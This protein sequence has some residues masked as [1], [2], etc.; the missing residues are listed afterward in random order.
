M[1]KAKVFIY[2]CLLI[3][4]AYRNLESRP[5]TP[6]DENTALQ[7]ALRRLSYLED[8]FKQTREAIVELQDYYT[9]PAGEYVPRRRPENSVID[10]TEVLDRLHNLEH[11][12][13]FIQDNVRGLQDY[14]G[15]D[16]KSITR[17]PYQWEGPPPTTF[18]YRGIR[19]NDTHPIVVT[20][21]GPAGETRVAG[22]V[23]DRRGEFEI[24]NTGPMQ[25]TRVTY[26]GIFL[27]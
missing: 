18:R 4:W 15:V 11:E 21:T 12:Y 20:S 27:S 24:V 14:T 26:Q 13:T 2:F 22:G 19:Y 10:L 16:Q 9:L 3:M 5:A 6:D 7:N 23:V 8:E 25:G 17:L 1:V